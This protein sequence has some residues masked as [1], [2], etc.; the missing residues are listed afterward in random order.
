MSHREQPFG[1]LHIITPVKDSIDSTL[2]TAQAILASSLSI[3][4]TY[5]IYNDFSTPENTARLEEASKRMGFRLV[6]LQDITQHPSPNY[7]LVLQRE[8]KSCLEENAALLIV[9]SDV[10]VRPN[11]LQGLADAALTQP[12]CGIA[13]SVTVDEKGEINYPYLYAKGKE[14]QLIDCRKH[15]SFCC[16][17]LTPQLFRCVDFDQLDSSKNWFDVTISHRSIESG[18]HNYLLTSLPVL[19]RPHGSRPW[20]QLKY[21][22]PL[23]YYWIKW[24]KG[25]DK[26]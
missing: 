21:K 13:A 10:T 7:L 26:I 3:P 16:S 15:C 18:L 22:N 11:T 5:T 8:R 17:L 2:E 4:Y 24:T 1:K 14:N 23:K 12:K 6:N 20:K 19:H 9:E 25:F